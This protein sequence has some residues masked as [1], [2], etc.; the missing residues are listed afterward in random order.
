MFGMQRE[1][2]GVVQYKQTKRDDGTY[3]SGN[4]TM[5]RRWFDELGGFDEQFGIYPWGGLVAGEDTDLAWRGRR[6]GAES[7]L[8]STRRRSGI[9]PR[10]H[11]P[12]SKCSCNP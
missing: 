6:A 7:A 12:R 10:R 11:P 5:W 9:S 3:P 2:D 8:G 4:M 1:S